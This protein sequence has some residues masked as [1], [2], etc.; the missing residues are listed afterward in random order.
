[1]VGAHRFSSAPTECCKHCC[2]SGT[3]K[4]RSSNPFFTRCLSMKFASRQKAEYVDVRADS[5]SRCLRL[6]IGLVV[7][8]T[9]ASILRLSPRLAYAAGA[10]DTPSAATTAWRDGRFQMDVSQVVGRSDV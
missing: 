2:N 7:V 9:V 5:F 10:T 1:M 8:F 3:Q 4:R 6:A